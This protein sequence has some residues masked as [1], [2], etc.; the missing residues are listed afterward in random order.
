ML[1]TPAG[2]LGATTKRPPVVLVTP[3]GKPLKVIVTEFTLGL[4]T[5]PKVIL[6]ITLLV[7]P[8]AMLSGI[9]SSVGV[10]TRG[11]F[12]KFITAVLVVILPKVPVAVKVTVTLPAL[13]KLPV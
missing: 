13:H 2:V 12:I 4:V 9:C 6:G 8:P 7:V 11:V 3:D 5:P 1:C 10:T